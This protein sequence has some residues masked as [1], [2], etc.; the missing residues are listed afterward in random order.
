MGKIKNPFFER[1]QEANRK[2]TGNIF[3]QERKKGINEMVNSPFLDNTL[4]KYTEFK[5]LDDYERTQE[6]LKKTTEI[7]L[8]YGIGVPFGGKIIEKV[9]ELE[10]KTGLYDQNKKVFKK[11]KLL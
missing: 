7:F 6:F 3:K 4:K 1:L 5:K 9:D 10:K 8:E 2:V 11:V